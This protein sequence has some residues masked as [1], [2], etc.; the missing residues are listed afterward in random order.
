LRRRFEWLFLSVC[1]FLYSDPANSWAPPDARTLTMK[2]SINNAHAIFIGRVVRKFKRDKKYLHEP[3]GVYYPTKGIEVQVEEVLMGNES[4]S[5]SITIGYLKQ[6]EGKENTF[7]E[8][9]DY[10]FV[11][12]QEPPE[13]LHFA[14]WS[15]PDSVY[16]IKDGYEM[17]AQSLDLIS[18]FPGVIGE[19]LI[20]KSDLRAPLKIDGEMEAKGV[21]GEISV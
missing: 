12:E 16:L 21:Q 10:L 4:K 15:M 2:N 14:Q 13:L 6:I 3:E 9:K 17:K 7:V 20:S 11:M 1:L 19:K 18:V 5:G 8:R